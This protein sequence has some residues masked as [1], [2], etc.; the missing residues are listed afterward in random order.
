MI[1]RTTS[2][3]LLGLHGVLLSAY[4]VLQP[5]FL[6]EQSNELPYEGGT[7]VTLN[8]VNAPANWTEPKIESFNKQSPQF[9]SDLAKLATVFAQEPESARG[10]SSEGNEDDDNEDIFGPTLK[11]YLT[12]NDTKSSSQTKDEIQGLSDTIKKAKQIQKKLPEMEKNLSSLQQSYKKNNAADSK[13]KDAEVKA[14]LQAVKK[15]LTNQINQ[16]KA[17]QQNLE[18]KAKQIDSKISSAGSGSGSTGSNSTAAS[19]LEKSA[20]STEKN[21][22]SLDTIKHILTDLKDMVL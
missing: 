5:A 16:L 3:V 21:S 13:A 12:G 2:L 6:E 15:S 18:A 11:Q 17:T 9:A 20:T 14:Q 10:P 4:P 1:R 8:M 22:L 19:L 7:K